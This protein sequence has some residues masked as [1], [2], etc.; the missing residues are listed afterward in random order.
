M[1]PEPTSKASEARAINETGPPVS[2]RAEAEAEA[3]AV[4]VGNAVGLAV[5]EAEPPGGMHPVP[6]ARGTQIDPGALSGQLG[7][8]GN[9]ILELT[10]STKSPVLASVHV[11]PAAS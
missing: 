5:G 10:G 9:S 4:A 3:V 11:V 2:G 7:P 8:L 6:S 1:M